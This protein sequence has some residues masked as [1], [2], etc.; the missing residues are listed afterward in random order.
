MKNSSN[1]GTPREE[2]MRQMERLM[3]RVLVLL[4]ILLTVWSGDLLA[5]D[6][7]TAEMQVKT[8]RVRAEM[9]QRVSN[10]ERQAAADALKALREKVYFYQQQQVDLTQPIK[11]GEVTFQGIK[12]IDFD[13]IPTGPNQLLRSGAP[14]PPDY[15]TTANWAFT[16][17]IAK[18]VDTVSPLGCT[19]TNNLGQ[20]LP[21][22]VPDTVTY[23]GSDYYEIVLRQWQEPMHSDMPNGT[24]TRG[25]IQTNYGTVANPVDCDAPN[26]LDPSAN[27]CN[28]IAPP[29]K[30]H[31]LGP[32]IIA[33]RDR[34]VRIKFTNELPL[35]AGGDLYIPVDESV[36][37]AGPGPLDVNGNPCDNADPEE[38]SCE[39]YTQNRAT[40]HLHGGRTPWI[41]DG[42]P[43]QWITPAGEDT[44][45]P[46]GVS[47]SHVPD[48][49]IPTPGDGS[50]T[51]YYTNQQTARLMFYHD[52]A[53]GITRINV[54][55]G[56][57][58]G[59]LITDEWDQDL[60]NRDI[61][62]GNQ[63]DEMIPLVIQDR[64][65]VDATPVAN[66]YNNNALT[67][68][69]RVTDPLWNWGTG[70]FEADG[71]TRIPQ[72][73][74]LWLPHVY[75]PAQNPFIPDLSGLNP[76]G[77]WLYG[78]W[79]YPPTQVNHPPESNPYYDP[80]CSSTV[81]QVLADCQTPGQPP[82]IPSTPHPSM[83]MEA[84]FD[85]WIVNGTA[86][87][88]LEVEPKAYRFRIL[89]AA[90]DR[91]LNMSLY[92]ADS[93]PDNMSPVNPTG[94]L[95]FSGLPVPA[96]FDPKTEVKIVEAST[97]NAAAGGWPELWPV[98]G[99]AEGVP[100]PGDCSG[101]RCSNFGPEI[102]Q[103]GTDAGSMPKP[104]VID[105]QPV[106]WN[107]D[108]TAFWVGIVQDVGLALMPAERADVVIDFSQY[109]GKTLILYNDAPAAWPAG[110][111]NFDYWTGAPDYRDSG[112]YG[113]GGVFNAVT[114][115]Y[116][117]GHGPLPGF[118]PN[119]RTVMQIK[120]SAA[121][122][123]T[124]ESPFS[125]TNLEKEFTQS[126]PTS[127]VN[128][129]KGDGF[130][131]SLFERAMEPIIVAQ[132]AY[133]EAYGKTFPAV[134]PWGGF[135][136][137]IDDGH[138]FTFET[139]DGEQVTVKMK[140]KG[141]HDEMGASFDPEYGRMS[142]NLAIEIQPPQTNNANLNLYAYSDVPTEF[143]ENSTTV[144]VQVD[145]LGQL[146][147]GTQIWNISHNGVDTHPI[148]FH[149]FDVQVI[150]RL[151]WDNQIMLPPEN[152]LGWK[153]TVRI[154]PLMDTVV[155]VRPVAPTLPFGLPDSI[156]PLNPML[157]IGSEMGFSSVDPV[158]G[159]AYQD[160]AEWAPEN[161]PLYPGAGGPVDGGIA[162]GV[163]NVMYNFGWEYV[164][165][166]HI[167]SHEE[168]DMMR[169]IILLVLTTPPDQTNFNLT[170]SQ[171]T[172]GDLTWD[173]PTPVNYANYPNFLTAGTQ[174]QNEIGFN[175][176]RSDGGTA[177]WT[178]I[179]STLANQLAYTDGTNT[180][181]GDTYVIEAYNATSSSYSK[182]T[183]LGVAELTVGEGL[184]PGNSPQ[185]LTLTTTISGPIANNT[186]DRVEYY[187]GLTLVGTAPGTASASSYEFVYTDVQ[188]GNHELTAL[189]V[190]LADGIELY[191]ADLTP[192][193]VTIGP[194]MTASFTL[195]ATGGVCD[196]FN[197]TSSVTGGDGTYTYSWL[198]DG[199]VH[200]EAGVPYVGTTP[201]I[202]PLAGTTTG[203]A[204]TVTMIVTQTS[205]GAFA[206]AN[207]VVT[208]TN[209]APTAD[210]GGVA[211]E[212]FSPFNG[213]VTLT[214]T[215]EDTADTCDTLS[216][217]WD[218]DGNGV[219]DY[220]SSTRTLKDSV[221]RPWLN[222]TVGGGTVASGGTAGV[223]P[224]TITFKVTDSSGAATTATATLNF[225]DAPFTLTTTA[226]A[227]AT[228]STTV[229]YNQQLTA[230]GGTVGAGYTWTVFGLPAG[231]SLNST[232][233]LISGLPDAAN[234]RSGSTFAT[235]PVSIIA[236]DNAT[237]VKQSIST[238]LYL[239][240]YAQ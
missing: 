196:T 171:T 14:K 59:Y 25:Y 50:M 125:M 105:P 130:G 129:D 221:L 199:V 218:I 39:Y 118:A 52:H 225:T 119:T 72:T 51:F 232:T 167:L 206:T 24:P 112:G 198:V 155:A 179:G 181:T 175:V 45:Y 205:N 6:A 42:T 81:P 128:A 227:S 47:V 237:P 177:A 110:V 142:G 122:T 195:P 210:A 139:I 80:D 109:A 162:P 216:Y 64:T 30:G 144:K 154:S 84:F 16:P 148:H 28:G 157:K 150:S 202:G 18:F 143:V 114:G 219:Y 26:P 13:T 228:V 95:P 184:T 168:M 17:P 229:Q 204:H 120:V 188:D 107:V 66:P 149:I 87:P 8:D 74:D 200:N 169:A 135:R 146:D 159:Q 108:P 23:P 67:P 137:S 104:M 123:V 3:M 161:A 106:N 53:F 2:K 96:G 132:S 176:W 57:A 193:T 34:P 165:H 10:E 77:R 29:A 231:L 164:W 160:A 111:F 33:D 182:P 78:P 153:D 75:M 152:Q 36:M 85:S 158:T 5:A 94:N 19:E 133:D 117:G 140:P 48:M 226:L 213:L 192:L 190:A 71:I 98:D 40:V 61:I 187:D 197:V 191:V 97:T 70:P 170:E 180:A 224:Y 186:I 185:D 54:L 69:I 56:M 4:T 65:F 22:A 217:A 172:A 103:I 88:R 116:E 68:R 102:V 90:N 183:V 215:G 173:D 44:S 209:T 86:F 35:G 89:N 163:H 37:G 100:D 136:Y 235:F 178:K 147:D 201:T 73:G 174:D 9:E 41:S 58:A 194:A 121:G 240:V 124:T 145:V 63:P 239:R 156:R 31:F 113:D 127:P 212:Y 46:Q 7:A 12:N 189:V 79:F 49:P 211:G 115:L 208:I 93:T 32:I 138:I 207:N 62:P 203:S 101:A 222:A 60:M 55:A 92:V 27:S 1:N 99:R 220:Y 91:A 15:N 20:C 230:V 233:G 38:N 236:V 43:H 166:C 134:A 82:L 238:V 21:V 131:E 214:G 234:V 141:I 11:G 223:G 151:G 126:A 76:F 83:G